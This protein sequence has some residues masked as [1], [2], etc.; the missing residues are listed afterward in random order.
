MIVIRSSNNGGTEPAARGTISRPGHRQRG[1]ASTHLCSCGAY[2]GA[3]SPIHFPLGSARIQL[4]QKSLRGASEVFHCL[5]LSAGSSGLVA[6][7]DGHR[8]GEGKSTC[9]TTNVSKPTRLA[10]EAS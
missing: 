1:A 8:V 9:P 5:S 6:H 2:R 3:R 10:A 4:R 7:S